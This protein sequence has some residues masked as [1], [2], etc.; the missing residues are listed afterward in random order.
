MEE[1]KAYLESEISKTKNL[2]EQEEEKK[3]TKYR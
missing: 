1:L 3:E 2:L